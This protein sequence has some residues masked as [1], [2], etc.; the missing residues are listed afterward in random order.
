M[1]KA[2]NNYGLTKRAYLYRLLSASAVE[3]T[4]EA[5]EAGLVRG[6]GGRNSGELAIVEAAKAGPAND[7]SH[8]G[9]ARRR[10]EAA[11]RGGD[12]ICGGDEAAVHA[13]AVRAVDG[14]DDGDGG[15]GETGS[16][17]DE[18]RRCGGSETGTQRR[19]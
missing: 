14:D 19:Q 17:E 2:S 4:V 15:G 3:A 5:V 13:A 9:D 7:A 10:C 6:G 8:R 18:G 1:L 12:A 16:E 11:V